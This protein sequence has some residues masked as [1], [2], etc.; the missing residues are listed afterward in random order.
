VKPIRLAILAALALLPALAAAQN[1]IVLGGVNA[2]PSA[3]VEVTADTLRV[4]QTT[5]RAVFTGEVLVGQGTMRMSAQEVEVIYIAE[6]GDIARML[7]TGGV[8][9]V[10]ETEAAEADAADYDLTAGLLTLTGNVLVTQGQTVLSSERMVVNL[11]DGTAQMEGR[12]R[13]VFQQGA[14]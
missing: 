4:D 9:L 1:T 3:P 6:T 13:T 12:V 2:D 5:G 14:N 8:T 10:T 11:A 7:A